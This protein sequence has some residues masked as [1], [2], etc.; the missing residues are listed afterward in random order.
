MVFCLL[1]KTF[2]PRKVAKFGTTLLSMK[3]KLLALKNLVSHKFYAG[4]FK[5]NNKKETAA[6]VDFGAMT[7][8]IEQTVVFNGS[9]S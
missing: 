2:I 8:V 9:Y 6:A 7:L 4:F 1:R 3:K 5:H